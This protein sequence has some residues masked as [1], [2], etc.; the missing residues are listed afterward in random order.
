M[1]LNIY[2]EDLREETKEEIIQELKEELKNEIE[3]TYN[4]DPTADKQ[5]IENEIVDNYLNT[6]NFAQEISY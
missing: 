2:F 5:Q 6:H 3:E 1:K 4:L